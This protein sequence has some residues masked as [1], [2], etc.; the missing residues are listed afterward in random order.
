MLFQIFF[1]KTRIHF[2]KKRSVEKSV[3]LNT[4]ISRSA[5]MSCTDFKGSVWSGRFIQKDWNILSNVTL[6]PSSTHY[7]CTYVVYS[8]FALYFLENQPQTKQ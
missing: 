4:Q 8:T 2:M 3:L 7:R 5:L 6:L 1:F